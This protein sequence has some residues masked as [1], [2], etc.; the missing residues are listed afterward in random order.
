MPPRAMKRGADGKQ[1]LLSDGVLYRWDEG[2]NALTAVARAPGCVYFTEPSPGLW[3]F[4]DKT[5]VYRV[6]F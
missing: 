6:R 4:A 1:Y 5:S 3:L 2:P